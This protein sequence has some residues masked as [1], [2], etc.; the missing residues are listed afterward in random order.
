ML[1]K[2]T[3]ICKANSLQKA[4]NKN[5]QDEYEADRYSKED[6][7]EIAEHL[8]VYCNNAEVEQS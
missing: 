6:L 7:K 8:L 5:C 3:V 1:I 4:F 2:S